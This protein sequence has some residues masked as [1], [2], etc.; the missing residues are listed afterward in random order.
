MSLLEI[1]SNLLNSLL[2]GAVDVSL[3]RG[4]ITPGWN[5]FPTRR[6]GDCMFASLAIVLFEIDPCA[7]RQ[8]TTD[9][10]LELNRAI[11]RLRRTVADAL[12]IEQVNTYIAFSG[13]V[14]DF[15][16]FASLGKSESE[17][18]TGAREI[19]L[20]QR[21]W[22][23][24][25]ALKTIQNKFHINVLLLDIEMG[26]V[27]QL[28]CDGHSLDWVVLELE[29]FH[30]RPVVFCDRDHGLMFKFRQHSQVV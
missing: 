14:S 16:I 17:N 7:L 15:Q 10:A 3:C 1:Q 25:F 21:Y 19:V 11:T 4:K 24:E 27:Q 23:D 12:T 30:Y 8:Y 18:L 22:G 9:V 13:A 26:K 20:S 5:T 28:P 29:H 6:N 2:S